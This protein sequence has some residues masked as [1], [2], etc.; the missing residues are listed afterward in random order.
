MQD[1]QLSLTQGIVLVKFRPGAL[2]TS[3]L[4]MDVYDVLDSDPEKYR[5]TN[6][7]F[8]ARDVSVEKGLD[9]DKIGSLLDYVLARRQAWPAH[10]KT[11]MVV[12]SKAVY[13]LGRVYAALVDFKI[14]LEVK[15]F[16]DDLQAA[17]DWAI[18]PA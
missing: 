8:D 18:P 9:F 7:V 6:L 13:G 12:N 11:A 14:G 17:I 5:T 4:I 2:I 10:N 3:Q 1:W 15:L 16:E